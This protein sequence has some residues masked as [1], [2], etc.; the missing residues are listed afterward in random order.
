ML[1]DNSIGSSV[2]LM[3][4]VMMAVVIVV[5]VAVVVALIVAVIVAV[6]VAVVVAVVVV[7][8]VMIIP[9]TQHFTNYLL[10]PSQEIRSDSDPKFFLRYTDIYVGEPS[11][12]EE[13]FVTSSVT[14][15]QCRLRDC[16]YS[17]PLFVN[18]KYTRQKNIVTKNGIQIG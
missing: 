17:A 18:I 2:D 15:F 7:V 4:V 5:V 6:E 11:L 14:P 10:L 12:D 3:V 1:D 13:A 8:I 16:T 9:T